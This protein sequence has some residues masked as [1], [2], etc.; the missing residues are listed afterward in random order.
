MSCCMCPINFFM[1][2]LGFIISC[3]VQIIAVSI[4]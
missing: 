4:T 2:L 3:Y 1:M